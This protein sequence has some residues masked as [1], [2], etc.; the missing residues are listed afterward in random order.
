MSL[1]YLSN[2]WWKFLSTRDLY[3]SLEFMY[4]STKEKDLHECVL[5]QVYSHE[6]NWPKIPFIYL[7]IF[8]YKYSRCIMN[9]TVTWALKYMRQSQW[10]LRYTVCGLS[11]LC[12][13]KYNRKPIL[14]RLLEGFHPTLLGTS[15]KRSFLKILPLKELQNLEK[16]QILGS[17]TPSFYIWSF[18]F[19]L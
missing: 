5:S 13:A 2:S 9:S 19:Y 4:Y 1:L 7:F 12:S 11:Q 6:G 8:I 18:F 17:T 16:L 14:Q 15:K 3:K 10:T